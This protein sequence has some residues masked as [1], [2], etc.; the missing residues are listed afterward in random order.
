MPIDIIANGILLFP[1]SNR[2]KNECTLEIMNLEEYEEHQY[3]GIKTAFRM[4]PH[5]THN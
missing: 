2:G 5:P 1:V 3:D 4:H